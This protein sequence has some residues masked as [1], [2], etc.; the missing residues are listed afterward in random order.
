V[1]DVVPSPD[2]KGDYFLIQFSEYALVNVP[3]C[4]KGDRNPVKYSTLEELGI[5]PSTLKW[6]PMPKAGMSP[7]PEAPAPRIANMPLTIADA[8][9]GLAQTYGVAPE[10]IEITI[11][12]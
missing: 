2:R 1:K 12:G 6:Q 3:N 7:T 4:W 11:R 9:K 10:A 8:K 5:D